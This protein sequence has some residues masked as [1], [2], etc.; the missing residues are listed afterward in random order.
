MVN[1]KV[2]EKI[3]KVLA[4]TKNNPSMEEAQ[5]AILIAQRMM[6]EHGITLQEVTVEDEPGVK[7]ITDLEA[8]DT[9][10][11]FAWKRVLASIIARN[12]R[13]TTWH[14][15]NS[16]GF[17]GLKTDAEI[18]VSVYDYATRII[19]YQANEYI[20]IQK[21][22]NF[23]A[24]VNWSAVRNSYILGFLYEMRDKF[25]EQVEKN[26]YGLILVKDP[27]VDDYVEQKR[28]VKARTPKITVSNDQEARASGYRQGRKFTAVSGEVDAGSQ[29]N[30]PA[31]G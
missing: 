1:E 11:M 29:T 25:N 16:R 6:A 24:R 27:A 31:I 5:A 21:R 2:I 3:R 14:C 13:C 12:F 10:R 18:A 15:G 28:F 8:K 22:Q 20:K 4:K 30:F 17:I 26:N 9:G 7:E 23:N 19:N